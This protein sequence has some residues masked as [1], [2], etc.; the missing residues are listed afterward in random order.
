MARSGNPNYDR[1]KAIIEKLVIGEYVP[2]KEFF[3]FNKLYK[4]FPDFEFWAQ[5]TST[6][7]TN[8]LAWFL[9]KWGIDEVNKDW[10][11]Y[12]KSKIE[13]VEP[14][15]NLDFDAT[16]IDLEQIPRIVKKKSII[17]ILN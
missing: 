13:K 12:Q 17:D 11:N 3:I 14:Q 6:K 9:S 1:I 7:K 16:D 15:L 10:N 2:K 5:F 4:K 8:S